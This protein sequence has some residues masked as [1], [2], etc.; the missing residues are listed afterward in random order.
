MQ[1]IDYKQKYLKYKAKYLEL[2]GG[3]RQYDTT[4]RY[5]FKCP[6]SNCPFNND[7]Y[8]TQSA[9]S[10]ADNK[11]VLTCQGMGSCKKAFLINTL[12]QIIPKIPKNVKCLDSVVSII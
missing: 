12:P 3:I 2:K 10:C 11:L 5:Q 7:K 8:W 4:T 9:L 1:S 6:T